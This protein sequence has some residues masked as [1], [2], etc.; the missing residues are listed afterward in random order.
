MEKRRIARRH[1]TKLVAGIDRQILFH[2]SREFD[3]KTDVLAYFDRSRDILMMIR[4]AGG[5]SPQGNPSDIAKDE[6]AML[7]NPGAGC[8]RMTN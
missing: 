3:K 6:H 7:E 4:A 8:I 2:K 5:V 1:W